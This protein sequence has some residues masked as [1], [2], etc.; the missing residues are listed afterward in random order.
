MRNKLKIYKYI[1][2]YTYHTNHLTTNSIFNEEK[3]KPISFFS[4]PNIIKC[5]TP[6]E[7][8]SEVD[9]KTFYLLKPQKFKNSDKT[10]K[11]L[12]ISLSAEVY[13]NDS[14]YQDQYMDLR[15]VCKDKTNDYTIVYKDKI[16]KFLNEEHVYAHKWYDLAISK[17]FII[18]DMKKLKYSVCVTTP[19]YDDIWVPNSRITLRN[20]KIK[21]EGL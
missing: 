20:I 8:P 16:V 4:H 3:Y 13:I 5:T 17:E 19:I 10:Y 9:Y 6:K 2:L 7:K 15:F 14:V 11:K 18:K 1:H 21:V 12:R